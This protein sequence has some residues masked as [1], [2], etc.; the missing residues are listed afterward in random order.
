M[1]T[2]YKA[3]SLYVCVCSRFPEPAVGS[4]EIGTR[5]CR[6]TKSNHCRRL[7]CFLCTAVK[8]IRGGRQE[9]HRTP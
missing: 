8:A 3:M 2:Y 4:A 6:S 7:H 1:Y 9:S 5:P